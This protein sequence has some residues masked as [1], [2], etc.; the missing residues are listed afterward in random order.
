[1]REYREEVLAHD[2]PCG[3]LRRRNEVQK[4]LLRLDK[5]AIGPALKIGFLKSLMRARYDVR[6][7][8]HYGLAKSRYAH[9]TSPIRRYAD[10]LVH[11]ALFPSNRRTKTS[12]KETADH[13]SNTE[14]NSADAE[15]DSKDVKIFAYLKTHLEQADPPSFQG[16]VIEIRNF[17]FFIDVPDLTL[18]GLVHASTLTDDFYR[19]DAARNHLIGTKTRKTIKLGDTVEVRVAKVDS[20]KKQVDFI[21]KK[22]AA[23]PG[24]N[25]LS[26]RRS[27]SRKPRR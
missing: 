12:L 25:P 9:F 26:T 6:P 16:L 11:R 18:S 20:F 19:F 27:R 5:L 2:I 3:N 10:L 13:I 17:G 4:L 24:L 7:L 14:R 21:L 15:R 8:G 1:M 22:P 23:Q